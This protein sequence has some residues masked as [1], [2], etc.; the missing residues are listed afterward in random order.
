MPYILVVYAT[1]LCSGTILYSTVVHF[2]RRWVGLGVVNTRGSLTL[3]YPLE[4][5]VL[6]FGLAKPRSASDIHWAIN[7]AARPMYFHRV[8]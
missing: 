4:Q 7:Q 6:L 1:C 3:I 2:T 5:G 8:E